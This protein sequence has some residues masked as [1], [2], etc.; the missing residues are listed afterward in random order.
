MIVATIQ[1]NTITDPASQPNTT[2]THYHY[3]PPA[4]AAAALC[5]FVGSLGWWTSSSCCSFPHTS[6]LLCLR[7]FLTFRLSPHSLTHSLTPLHFASPSQVVSALAFS[8]DS[9]TD[10]TLH[11]PA[12]RSRSIVAAVH[13]V[14]SSASLLSRSCHLPPLVLPLSCRTPTSLSQLQPLTHSPST[15]HPLIIPTATLPAYQSISLPTPPTQ[16]LP[17]CPLSSSR[18]SVSF[19]VDF[20]SCSA[21]LTN[22]VVCVVMCCVLCVMQVYYHRRH[23]CG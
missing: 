7:S 16:S 15:Y 19:I 23:W 20:L 9:R 17:S 18:T 8:L 3:S 13:R 14:S 5:W 11:P 4:V 21:P 22:L 6:Q 2:H 1:T 12:S 10:R